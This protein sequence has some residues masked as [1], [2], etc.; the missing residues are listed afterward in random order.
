MADAGRPTTN[1]EEMLAKSA[2]YL[3][4]CEDEEIERGSDDR[5]IYHLKVKLPTIE[6]FARFLRVNRDTLYTGAGVHPAFS[7]ILDDI[8]SEQ[9]DELISNGL[10]GDYNSTIMS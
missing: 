6:G 9:A 1:S 10:S 4:S 7:D 5:P 8:S 2:V 3:L